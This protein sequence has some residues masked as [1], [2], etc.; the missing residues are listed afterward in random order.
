[1]SIRILI[2]PTVYFLSI[3]FSSDINSRVNTSDPSIILCIVDL[4]FSARKY[5]IEYLWN[6]CSLL[7]V[8]TRAHTHTHKYTSLSLSLTRS[9]SLSVHSLLSMF[10]PFSSKRPFSLYLAFFPKRSISAEFPSLS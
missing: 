9:S 7:Q 4:L 6:I 8:H 5:I 3:L 2:G 10:P 1:M